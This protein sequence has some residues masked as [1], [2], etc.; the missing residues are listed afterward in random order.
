M[1]AGVCTQVAALLP[2]RVYLIALL[3]PHVGALLL[4]VGFGRALLRVKVAGV[5]TI[6]HALIPYVARFST[7]AQRLHGAPSV[8]SA[9]AASRSYIAHPFR[10][11]RLLMVMESVGGTRVKNGGIHS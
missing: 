3:R 10:G 5:K 9:L 11:Y 7:L 2:T 1:S 6:R 4:P 8:A